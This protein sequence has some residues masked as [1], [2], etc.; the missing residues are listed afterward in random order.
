MGNVIIDTLIFSLIPSNDRARRAVAHKNNNH[1][2]PSLEHYG[3]KTFSFGFFTESKQPNMLLA[4]GSIGSDPT[5]ADF[6]ID[7][8][9]I[10]D[11]HCLFML[12]YKTGVVMLEVSGI[13]D[14]SNVSWCIFGC[15]TSLY[16]PVKAQTELIRFSLGTIA[17]NI[18]YRIDLSEGSSSS[19]M[20][21]QRA[22]SMLI[23]LD[24]EPH[25]CR[26]THMSYSWVMIY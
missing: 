4:L 7:G 25:Y 13:R 21:G 3:E 5:K 22:S 2:E 17:N 15:S 18:Q 20:I 11:I 8:D 9:D 23:S 10:Q 19:Q 6:Y 26:A 16:E 1:R 14:F 12:N 24:I